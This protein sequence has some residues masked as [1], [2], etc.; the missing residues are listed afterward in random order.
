MCDILE[1]SDLSE[2][3]DFSE[4]AGDSAGPEDGNAVQ[5]RAE[6]RE[7][8]EAKESLKE[9]YRDL[10]PMLYDMRICRRFWHGREYREG[11]IDFDV[12]ETQILVDEEATWSLNLQ[13]GGPPIRSSKNLC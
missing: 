8:R 1:E 12:A 6:V 13:S 2:S 3:A 9:K 5:K 11:S 7:K 4:S 10:L